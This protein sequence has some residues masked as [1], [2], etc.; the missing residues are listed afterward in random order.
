MSLYGEYILEREGYSIIEDE[1]GFAT[2]VIAK[3][4]VYVRDVYVKKEFRQEGVA[5]QYL[6][7][8]ELEAMNVNCKWIF[9]SVCVNANGTS[10]SLK[11]VLFYGF[12]LHSLKG[13]MAYFKKELK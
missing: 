2:Y 12:E 8:I 10:D 7:L 9:T 6:K 11:A 5:S 3:D 4:E 13:E 1:R